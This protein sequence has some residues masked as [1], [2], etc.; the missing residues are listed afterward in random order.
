MTNERMDGLFTA[1]FQQVVSNPASIFIILPV[2]IFAF[3]LEVW[4][5]FP[6]KLVLPMCLVSGSCLF[7]GLVSRNTVS[8]YFPN[9]L[10]VLILNGFILGFVAWVVHKTVVKRIITWAGVNGTVLPMKDRPKSKSDTAP[11]FKTDSTP[12]T[13]D[14]V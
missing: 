8:P 13:H 1:L 14:K 5:L 12:P 3:V 6:S 2:S 7:P 4:P 11:P 10:L 9:P